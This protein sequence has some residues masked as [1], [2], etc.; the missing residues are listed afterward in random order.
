MTLG[1]LKE[2]FEKFPDNTEFKFGLSEPFSWRGSYNEVAFS[3]IEGSFTKENILESI[4][5][6]YVETFFGYKGGEYKYKSYTHVNFEEDC[7]SY[8]NNGYILTKLFKYLF[9]K[10]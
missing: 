4:N 5:K 3:I 10:E 2:Y 7:S 8:S 1:E 6:A 9:E